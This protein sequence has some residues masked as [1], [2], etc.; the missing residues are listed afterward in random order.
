MIA[1]EILNKHHFKEEVPDSVYI[2][3]GSPFGNPFPLADLRKDRDLCFELYKSFFLSQ[4]ANSSTYAKA[5]Y[6]LNDND[7]LVCFCKPLLCHGDFIQEFK[8]TTKGLSYKD[9]RSHFLKI[10]NYEFLPTLEGRTH[11]NIYS[12]S[13]TDLGLLTSN[14]TYS[15]FEH[16]KLGKFASME[17]FWFY[18]SSGFKHEELR[19]MYGNHAKKFGSSLP[20]VFSNSFERL[21]EEGIRCKVDQNPDLKRLLSE[22]HLP[23]K[24]YYY[25]GSKDECTVVREGNGLLERIYSDIS[26]ELGESFKTIIAGSRDLCDVNWLTKLVCDSKIRI[27]EVVEGGA[28]GV[29]TFGMYYALV[30]NYNLKTFEVSKEEWNKTKAAGMIRNAEMGKY[31]DKAIIG[32][33][34]KSRG[35]SHMKDFMEKMG[36]EVFSKDY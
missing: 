5:V 1:L 17:G 29:D 16:P 23:F 22:N 25:Y 9:A 30:N 10:H 27:S 33:K 26:R 2:G 3:R 8:T 14:F 32:I 11:I 28:K 7:R 15:P 36:K 18:V 4:L 20:K 12:K 35:S 34:D 31:A 6:N 13:S 24:H 21:I 19:S